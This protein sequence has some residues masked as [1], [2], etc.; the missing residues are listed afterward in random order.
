MFNVYEHVFPNGKRYIGITSQEPENRWKGGK[1]YFKNPQMQRA[2]RKYG[3]EHIAHNILACDVTKE[4]AE[5]MEIELIARYKSNDPKCGYNICS[6]GCVN[7]PTES[8]RKKISKAQTGNKIWLGRKHSE[9][10]KK[11][12]A[13]SKQSI[14]EETRLKMSAARAKRITKDETRTK[15]SEIHRGVPKSEQHKAAL[16]MSNYESHRTEQKPVIQIISNKSSVTYRGIKEASRI[17]GIASASIIRCCKGKQG[18][19]G[20]YKWMY[21][22]VQDEKRTNETQ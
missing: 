2:I 5:S 14:S 9:E 8:S 15:Q 13:L 12:I 11:K 3:W 21:K 20:G 19:A 7:V 6:G 17:T 4:D 1:G 16:S 18:T 10:S 22:E